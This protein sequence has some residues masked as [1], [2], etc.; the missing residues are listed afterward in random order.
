LRNFVAQGG[1]VALGNDYGGGRG[2]FE[3]GVPM[4]EIEK[5]AEAGM[6]PSQILIACTRNAAHV[7]GVEDELGTLES[8]KIADVLI[9][10]GD[11]LQNITALENP[12]I[13]IHNGVIIRQEGS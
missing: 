11:P 13:V 12:W 5:M 1:Q 2:E 6:T 8:G 7:A 10:E 9:V 3:L 4:Y